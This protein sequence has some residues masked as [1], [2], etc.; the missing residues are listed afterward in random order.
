MIQKIINT[1]KKLSGITYFYVV[2]RQLIATRTILL[3]NIYFIFTKYDYK[4]IW[5]H[6][7]KI[8]NKNYNKIFFY[9]AGKLAKKLIPII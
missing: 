9:F 4:D 8:T 6:F 3:C 2:L 5:T 7:F 1:I